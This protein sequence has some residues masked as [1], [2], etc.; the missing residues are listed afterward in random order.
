[1]IRRA[2]HDH[3]HLSFLFVMLIIMSLAVVAVSFRL[4]NITGIT[5]TILQSDK[6]A[7]GELTL[8]NMEAFRDIEITGKSFVVY[9]IKQDK[10][11]FAKNENT[12]LPLASLTKVM[13]AITARLHHTKI[14]PIVIEKKHLDGKFDLGLKNNQEWSLNEILKYTLVFSSNDGALAI[15]WNLGGY[16]AFINQ[17]NSDATLLGFSLVFTNPAGLD[18]G[19]L[20]GGE[21]SAL[22]A[23]KML[24]YARIH[25]PELLDPTTETRATFYSVDDTISGIPNTNQHIDDIV[26]A[27]ASKT[28]FTDSAGGNLG[29]VVDLTVGNPI[30]IVVLGSTREERFTDVHKLYNALKQSVLTK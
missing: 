28:G 16:A 12:S 7:D 29:V 14:T 5:N 30:A 26:D 18:E 25:F 11:I 24:A 2:R 21:G 22:N 10:V 15:A 6:V 27:V 3:I 1:M 19:D 20:L 17:M 8:Y 13:T 9:D 4:H 23:A